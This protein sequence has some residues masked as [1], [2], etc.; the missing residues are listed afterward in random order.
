MNESTIRTNV[1]ELV[2]IREDII[3][4]L[5]EVKERIWNRLENAEDI[6]FVEYKKEDVQRLKD[7]INSAID[8]AEDLNI[9]K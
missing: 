4:D 5:E 2:S 8:Y 1:G 9:E 3:S 7:A 6:N